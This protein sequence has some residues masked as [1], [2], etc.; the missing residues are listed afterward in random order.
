MVETYAVAGPIHFLH[1][2]SL[3]II[4]PTHNVNGLELFPLFEDSV[5]TTTQSPTFCLKKV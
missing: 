4:D 1:M 5:Y 3:E 2:V